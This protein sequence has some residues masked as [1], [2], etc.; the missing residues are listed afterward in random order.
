M[1]TPARLT[2]FTST[3]PERLTKL[4]MLDKEGQPTK[5]SGGEM[6]RGSARIATVESVEAFAALLQS[7]THAEARR[8]VVQANQSA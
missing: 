7:L 6:V 3:V 1:T 2:V 5:I 4:W 8:A